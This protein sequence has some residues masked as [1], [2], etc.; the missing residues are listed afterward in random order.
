MVNYIANCKLADDWRYGKA[1]YSRANPPPV[2]RFPLFLLFVGSRLYDGRLLISR[3]FL[4]EPPSSTDGRGSRD[5]TPVRPRPHG[6]RHRRPGFGGGRHGRRRRGG[7][8][9]ARRLKVHRELRGLAGRIRS[10]SCPAS[11][12]GGRPSGRGLVH[13]TGCRW[14]R[15]EAPGRFTP[16]R[17]SAEEVQSLH[18]GDQARRRGRESGL[19]PLGGEAASGGLSVSRRLP[20]RML[21]IILFL[22]EYS[23]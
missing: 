3:F 17:Q 2:V 11:P 1:P 22:F 20:G 13:R 19:L 23:S 14:W 4:A 7:Q 12:A 9:R 8:C 21:F 10:R 18:R 15:T 5:R 6:G 16:L